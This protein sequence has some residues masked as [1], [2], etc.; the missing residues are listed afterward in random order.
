MNTY[1]T[2]DE[3]AV[4]FQCRGA[5]VY[6]CTCVSKAFVSFV[7]CGVLVVNSLLRC[8]AR[9]DVCMGV[10]GACGRMHVCTGYM[11]VC[12]MGGCGSPTSATVT[13]VARSPPTAAAQSPGGDVSG[14]TGSLEEIFF[15]HSLGAKE[16]DGRQFAKLCKDS[17]LLSKR[18]FTSIDVDIIFAKVKGK[19][20]RKLTFAQFERAVAEVATVLGVEAEA[21]TARLVAKGGPVFSGVRADAVRLHDDTDGYTGV[22][23]RAAFAC[24]CN[25]IQARVLLYK[26]VFAFFTARTAPICVTCNLPF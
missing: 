26:G 4:W 11:Y 3:L 5:S 21:V 20:S 23:A 13:R 1:S 22:C 8:L 16:M 15:E 9:L 10:N 24:D 25:A 17:Q 12:V 19:G 6:V 7:P 18:K 2:V 14:A